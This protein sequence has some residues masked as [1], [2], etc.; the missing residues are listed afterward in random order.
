[1]QLSN[2]RLDFFFGFVGVLGR[3]TINEGGSRGSKNQ[4]AASA[5]QGMYEIVVSIQSLV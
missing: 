1:M 2:F 3:G 5:K 4:N